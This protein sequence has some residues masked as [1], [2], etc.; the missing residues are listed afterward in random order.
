MAKKEI[1]KI[2]VQKRDQ[3]GKRYSLRL[4]KTGR[5]PAVIYGRQKDPLHVHVDG[6]EMGALL[7][8][9]THLV[10]VVL[11]KAAEPCLVKEVQWDHLGDEVI[12]VDLSR[13]DLTSRVKVEIGLTLTGDAIGLKEAGTILEQ[14]FASIEVECLA[15]E[16]PDD[17][18]AEVSHLKVDDSLRVS[19]LKVPEGVKVLLAK[20]TILAAVR[21]LAEE[22]APT[23]TAAEGEASTEPEV[24]KKKVEEPGA[25]GDAKAGDKAAAKPAA[26]KKK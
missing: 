1:P 3:L 13:V 18:K 22:A 24:I 23:A 12:H 8:K 10:E 19:D 7:D 16:I 26:D 17:I 4:R 14:Y 20:E 11:D 5:L 15:T 25:E 9:H 21:V 6:K 2:A